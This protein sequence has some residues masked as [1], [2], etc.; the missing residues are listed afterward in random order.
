VASSHTLAAPTPSTTVPRGAR[1]ARG[2]SGSLRRSSHTATLGIAIPIGYARLAA[3]S[4]QVGS[5]DCRNT[6]DHHSGEQRRDVGSVE[7]VASLPR[8]RQQSVL[9]QLRQRARCAG[10]RLRRAVEHVE[11]QEPH[12][13]ALGSAAEQRRERGAEHRRQIA[14]RSR[15]SRAR[16]PATRGSRARPSRQLRTS[17]AARCAGD[18]ASRPRG[19]R[20]PRTP[21]PRSRSATG[22]PSRS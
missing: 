18:R 3:A 16:S 10:Q 12:R 6:I 22:P 11:H 19:R 21:A 8:A 15:T 17:P 2:R 5:P 7:A 13:G 9:G 1:Y 14:D 4:T 20:R